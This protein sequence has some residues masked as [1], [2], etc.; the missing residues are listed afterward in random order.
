MQID[1]NPLGIAPSSPP[2]GAIGLIAL[3][4]LLI[5]VLLPGTRLNASVQM[6]LCILLGLAFPMSYILLGSDTP[7]G[8]AAF[9]GVPL[10]NLWINGAIRRH[11]AGR[12]KKRNNDA[13][14]SEP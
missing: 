10:W 14:K 4:C 5:P 7:V 6:A 2:E 11:L 9:V 3:T 12:A 13:E 8:C 1:M